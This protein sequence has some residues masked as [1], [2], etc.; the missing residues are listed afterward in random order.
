MAKLKVNFTQLSASKNQKIGFFVED[1]TEEVVSVSQIKWWASLLLYQWNK[2]KELEKK[3]TFY[4]KSP[5]KIEAFIDSKLVATFTQIRITKD[6]VVKKDRD[7]PF[8][9]SE[10]PYLL[11][12]Y[13]EPQKGKNNLNR[14]E[15]ARED[16]NSNKHFNT[17]EFYNK[18]FPRFGSPIIFTG[19][20]Q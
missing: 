20:T 5:I 6:T 18:N 1:D 13:L 10:K 12:N 15:K 19:W 11:V 2:L 3:Q 16:F 7:M 14:E 4:K 17:I 9:F 8:P